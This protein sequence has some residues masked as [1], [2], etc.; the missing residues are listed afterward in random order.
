MSLMGA[1]PYVQD[2]TGYLCIAVG[3]QFIYF[4]PYST[5]YYPH[6][7]YSTYI[8]GNTPTTY[9]YVLSGTTDDVSRYYQSN[10]YV[11]LYDAVMQS[12]ALFYKN[13]ATSYTSTVYDFRVNGSSPY[14]DY[15][16]YIVGGKWIDNWENTGS[17]YVSQHFQRNEI[18]YS[19]NYSSGP[20]GCHLKIARNMLDDGMPV[21]KIAVYTGLTANE[22]EKLKNLQ[23]V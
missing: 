5:A 18:W 21:D 23:L 2:G 3:G 10:A 22:I 8:P 1:T 17:T 6:M 13:D 15:S 14:V 11:P 19:G 4:Y 12:G 9:S 20:Y 7:T 16:T